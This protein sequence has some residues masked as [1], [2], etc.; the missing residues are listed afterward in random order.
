MQNANWGL[1]GQKI[2]QGLID[3]LMTKTF[4]EMIVIFHQDKD[5]AFVIWKIHTSFFDGCNKF[6]SVCYNLTPKHFDTTQHNFQFTYNYTHLNFE[7][8][9]S[10]S[11]Q[12]ESNMIL[13]QQWISN[14]RQLQGGSL[15]PKPML[16]LK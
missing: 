1:R 9:H 15:K 10:L 11:L 3:I 16:Q 12:L 6:E 7:C 8:P 2:F 13:Y 5:H 4:R 14:F